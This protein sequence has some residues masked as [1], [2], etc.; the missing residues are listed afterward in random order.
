[1][2]LHPDFRVSE[3]FML[4]GLENTRNARRR[5]RLSARMKKLEG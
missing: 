1:V 4:D 3:R 5:G 2:R